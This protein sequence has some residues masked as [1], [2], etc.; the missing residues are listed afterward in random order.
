MKK[1]LAIFLITAFGLAAQAPATSGST[2]RPLAKKGAAAVPQVTT[3]P[4][5]A[6]ANP[7]GTYAWTDK[8]GTKWIYSKT[9]FSVLKTKISDA[10]AM[11][12]LPA[13]M[14]VFDEGAKV[15]FA[16]PTPFGL[17]SFEKQKSDLSDEER[18]LLESQ[19]AAPAEKRD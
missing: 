12:T 15:R 7:D 16:V 18:K 9:P 17:T 6:V 3:I 10:P 2:R 5:D 1:T 11:T 8:D 13:N 14:K 19:T 4:K